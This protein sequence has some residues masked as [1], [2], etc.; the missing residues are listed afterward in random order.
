MATAGGVLTDG[1]PYSGYVIGLQVIDDFVDRL[2]SLLDAEVHL[3]VL[4]A[5]VRRHLVDADILA[6]RSLP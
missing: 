6:Q 5:D 4:A 3:V 2:D 1:G